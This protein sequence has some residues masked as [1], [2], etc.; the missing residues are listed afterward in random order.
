[1][2]V[3]VTGAAG[4]I[5]RSLV[6]GLTEAGH[7]VVGVDAVAV[8]EPWAERHVVADIDDDVVLGH[9]TA[10]ASAIVHLAA[11]V[12]ESDFALA[13][14]AHLVLTHR[15]LEAARSHGVRRVVYASSNH[16]VG[17]T[18]RA[19]IV[20]AE[21]RARPDTFYGFGKA[22]AEALCSLYHD[23]HGI[24]VACLRIGSF[25]PRPS[26]RRELSTWLSPADAVRLVDACLRAPELGFAV[27]Y[28]ISNNRRGW[29]D[30]STARA[31]GYEPLDDAEV[32]AAEIEATPATEQDNREA[33]FVGG[34]FAR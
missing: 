26:T 25:R 11:I 4:R 27:V 29:W 20:P 14:H 16:A 5:G 3:V 28:G 13:L 12:G 24:E 2:R 22:A 1:M 19:E 6:P 9:V 32:W 21:T 34:D 31:L 18:P 10:G 30:L 33:R 7:D 8:E 23:R 17:Y 15:V